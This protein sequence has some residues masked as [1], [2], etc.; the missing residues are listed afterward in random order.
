MNERSDPIVP[1]PLTS[2]DS[3]SCELVEDLCPA[4]VSFHFGLPAADLVDRVRRAGAVILSS[5]TTPA[6]AIWLEAHGCN[7]VIAQGSEA[8][9]H[10]GMFLENDPARQF[11]T[12]ALVPLV[13]DA[14]EIPVVAAG[15]IA[16][17]R[18]V[19]A[20]LALG[21][22]G[23]Q[24]GTGYL[25]CPENTISP[26]HRAALE[27]NSAPTVLTNVFT[28]RPARS[29][30]TRVVE[31]LG[32]IAQDIAPFPLPTP[33]M[34]PLRAAA[35]RRGLTDFTPLWSGQAAALGRAVAAGD[36]TR[37]LATGALDILHGAASR[38]SWDRPRTET[39]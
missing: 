6:E 24:I 37:S 9:G 32:P 7:V 18:G 35:E 36:L 5:A 30:V 4:V 13:V 22:S 3:E 19:A 31:E 26:L 10:R 28:G 11:G 29:I 33:A 16:D 2:F 14:V 27:D 15:G 39:R 34:L 21:A 12:M 38:S 23:V 17:A 20:A 8:G 25:R 1:P